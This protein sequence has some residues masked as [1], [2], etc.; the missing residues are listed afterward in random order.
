MLG[1]PF[2]TLW[3]GQLI[4]GVG[5]GM[6]AFALAVHAFGM[7]GRATDVSLVLLFAFLPPILLGPY[8]G[9]LADRHDRRFLMLIAEGFSITG[10][11][12]ILWHLSHGRLT[13]PYLL[14]GVTISALFSTLCAPAYKALVS[15]LVSREQYDRVGGLLQLSGAAGH[16]LAPVLAG[17]LLLS[18][19]PALILW[20]DAATFLI[21]VLVLLS[22]KG[23]LPVRGKPDQPLPP[24]ERTLTEGWSILRRCAGVLPLVWVLAIVTF[25]IGFVQT[26]YT[27]LLLDLADPGSLG[28]IRSVGALGL[29]LTSLVIGAKGLH[30]SLVSAVIK[31]L[32]ALGCFVFLLGGS[33]DLRLIGLF[34]F[35][36][37]STLPV[38]NTGADALLRRA[39]P[40]EE[41]GRA[42]GMVGML[43]QLGYLVAYASAGML[44]DR[45]F[46]PMM[47]A[48]GA[49]SAYLGPLIGTG[50]TRGIGLLFLISGLLLMLLSLVLNRSRG[51][52]NL[53]V[54]HDRQTLSQ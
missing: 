53:E 9:A 34:S 5:S 41:Q 26:L 35:L 19:G 46:N 7:R 15:E 2:L 25:L 45:I 4:S 42:W 33:T 22:L 43:S 28:L 39:I 13:L 1:R 24:M 3:T 49:L 54:S 6:T 18:R 11:L 37:F 51:F 20:L 21:T 16:L 8:A 48:G 27:P 10:L 38:I 44:T 30:G 36:L 14:I 23:H 52:S 17:F 47:K 50:A 31:G 32:F 40:R 12:W 29:L